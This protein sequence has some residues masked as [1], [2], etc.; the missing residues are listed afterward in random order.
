MKLGYVLL[1]AAA[2]GIIVSGTIAIGATPAGRSV[3]QWMHNQVPGH[4]GV[5]PPPN[6]VP[7]A[8]QN[9]DQAGPSLPDEQPVS[10]DQ[11]TATPPAI[12]DNC[13]TVKV[14]V[15][16]DNPELNGLLDDN[17]LMNPIGHVVVRGVALPGIDSCNH[18]KNLAVKDLLPIK[19]T[20]DIAIVVTRDANGVAIIRLPRDSRKAMIYESTCFSPEKLGRF[21]SIVKPDSDKDIR[22]PEDYFG[23]PS[24][25]EC[26]K[27]AS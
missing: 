11:A 24:Q 14:T 4:H 9:V 21:V 16:S 12:H 19:G 10:T 23:R 8:D 7:A 15:A 18:G 26:V 17:L 25:G 13:V 2:V 22:L 1:A 3:Q 20:G 27:H 5:L 6:L